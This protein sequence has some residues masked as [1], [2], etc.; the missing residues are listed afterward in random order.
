QTVYD[1]YSTYE[2]L[3]VSDI[4][5]SSPMG[6]VKAA[7]ITDMYA[8]A[9]G[10]QY[11]ADN[12]FAAAFQLAIWEIVYDYTGGPKVLADIYSGLFQATQTDNSPLNAGMS[13]ALSALFAA[14]G[15]NGSAN[16]VGLGSESWQDQILE[17]PGP[18]VISIG[19]I[20][21]VMAGRRRRRA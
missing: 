9:A 5:L 16:L 18:G 15:T 19:A 17:V 8:W 6:A 13:A 12:D 4:P 10:Y 2:V 1:N 7:A 21:L 14:I 3:N 11:T 20:G